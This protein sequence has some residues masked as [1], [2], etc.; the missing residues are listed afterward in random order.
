MGLSD[1]D[2]NFKAIE[3]FHPFHLG[4]DRRIKQHPECNVHALGDTK[5]EWTGAVN[6]V[7]IGVPSRLSRQ[8]SGSGPSS[9]RHQVERSL[10][11]LAHR[12]SNVL[13]IHDDPLLRVGLVA[14][15]RQHTAFAVV[16]DGVDG[17][18]PCAQSIDVVIADYHE[19][20]RLAQEAA[21]G[22]HRSLDAPRILA[23]TSN[24]RVA[25]IRHAIE[26][27]VHG[28][29][30]LGGPLEELIEGVTKVAN[31]VRFLCRAVARRLADS[32]T[33]ASL[34]SRETDV[35]RLLMTGK[36]NKA[37]AR[38]L[39]IAVGTVKSH[40][41][42]IMTKLGATTR[43]EAAGIAASRGLVEERGHWLPSTFPAHGLLESTG[44]FARAVM[45]EQSAGRPW[46]KARPTL[47]SEV[48]H[49]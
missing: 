15:L 22:A 46:N 14:A 41:K 49:G 38:Q 39:E 48:S 18:R 43:T 32:M 24:D 28:Y 31:G 10:S 3:A 6:C 34:T 7:Q 23:L 33:H 27:G 47:A 25:D 35:L 44:N 40:M 4:V 16:I 5:V 8:T 19:A 26:A 9:Q 12:C 21:R 1:W 2:A 20:T 42:A 11:H 36:S 45:V 37:I 30:L 13:V 29:L 17:L